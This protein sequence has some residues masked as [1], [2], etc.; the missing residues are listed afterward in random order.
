MNVN[1]TVCDCCAK[2]K[3]ELNHWRQIG[4]QKY[5]GNVWIELGMIGCHSDPSQENVR[6]Y[7]VHDLC[8]DQ[9]LKEH[10]MTLLR[11]NPTEAE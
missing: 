9:C 3:G 6:S 10:I 4:V 8:S 7:E 2:I 11:L 1:H 5:A